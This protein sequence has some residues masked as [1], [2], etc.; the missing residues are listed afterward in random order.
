LEKIKH[1]ANEYVSNINYNAKGQW[2]DVYYGNNTKTSYIYDNN[3]FRLTNLKTLRNSE[4]L[5][6]ISYVYDPVGNITEIE[7][8]AQQT[9]F[10]NNTEVKPISKY[11]YDALYRLTK[12]TGRELIGL[13]MPNNEDFANNRP[14][15]NNTQAMSI[16]NQ[17]YKYDALGNIIEMKNGN[18]WTRKYFYNFADNNYLLKHDENGINEYEYDLHG[19]M[20][21]MPH[22]QEMKYDFLNQLNEVVLNSSGNT[23]YY[24]YDSTGNRVR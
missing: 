17:T 18:I 22:L 3:N 13:N 7:D 24:T 15:P 21:K 19:N 20:L 14:L 4:Y 9:V 23:A 8:K 1:N 12:A 2:T 6:D 10:F 5:Q 11:E 16:Y